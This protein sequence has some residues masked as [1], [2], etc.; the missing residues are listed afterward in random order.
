VKILGVIN[1]LAAAAGGTVEAMVQQAVGMAAAGHTV[2]TLSLDAPGTAIDARL[3]AE[4]V[5]LVGPPRLNYGYTPKLVPWLQ[6]H[7]RDYDV[8]VVH[9]MWQYHGYAVAK[10]ARALGLRYV[11]FLHG[12]LDPWF[13][14][15]YPLKHLKKWLYWPWAEYRVLE[16]ARLVLFTAEDELRLA[17]E[18]FPLYAVRE[19]MVGFGVQRREI[20]AAEAREAFLGAFPHLRATRNLLFLSRIHPKKGCDLLIEAFARVAGSDPR[21]HLVLAGPDG[22]GWRATLAA[23][24]GQLGVAER[25]TFT[26]MLT[27]AVKW[28]A[29]DA[30]EVFV[31]PS[32]QEN[33]GIVVAE[34][35]ACGLPV[36]TTHKVNIWREIENAGAGLVNADTQAGVDR[37]LAD[38]LALSAA[39]RQAVRERALPCFEQSFEFQRTTSQ[40]LD[41][42]REAAFGDL[43]KHTY[44]GRWTRRLRGGSAA[45]AS[46]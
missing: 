10:V 1:T 2:H 24:A 27:G 7:G 32:H 41:A 31:L 38:W 30:A 15:Q 16:A 40:L 19:R 37:L 20:P 34:A 9:G 26:G 35:L 29:Y 44:R 33:F 36:L 6:Q 17:R 8:I 46:R 45:A 14:R 18:S 43:G 22:V 21:L 23:R 28:G 39:H 25:V 12:M 13:A 4:D 5:F 11:V 42:L 3:Q